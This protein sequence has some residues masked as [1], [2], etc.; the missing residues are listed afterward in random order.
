MTA[1]KLEPY[2]NVLIRNKLAL[3]LANNKLKEA[4]EFYKNNNSFLT[5]DFKN[6]SQNNLT[7]AKARIISLEK[8][9]WRESIKFYHKAVEE[10]SLNPITAVQLGLA[11]NEVLNDKTNFIKYAKKAFELDLN[12]WVMEIY[13]KALLE[14]GKFKE[15]ENLMKINIEFIKKGE[16]EPMFLFE[17][18]YH[19]KKFKEAQ[20][21]LNNNSFYN[22]FDRFAFFRFARNHAQLNNVKEV[23]QLLNSGKLAN[24]EKAIVFAILKERDSMYYYI[25]KESSIFNILEFNGYNELNPYRKEERYKEYLRKNYLPITHWNE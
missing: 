25:D 2:S 5:E 13:F 22:P 18:Y 12:N 11:Y 20:K 4:E 7:S 10:D 24:S 15:A 19:Q 14:G 3:L 1:N 16:D 21:I 17:Y 9:D 8:K 6:A 23:Y